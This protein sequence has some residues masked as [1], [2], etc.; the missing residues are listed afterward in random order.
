[1]T[2]GAEGRRDQRELRRG[3]DG[4]AEGPDQREVGQQP[5]QQQRQRAQIGGRGVLQFLDV[6]GPAAAQRRCG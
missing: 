2:A 5:R 4:E 6:G 1:M 3:R